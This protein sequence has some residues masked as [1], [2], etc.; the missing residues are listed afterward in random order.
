MVMG[1][2]LLVIEAG[3]CTERFIIFFRVSSRKST[4][5]FIQNRIDVLEKKYFCP[6]ISSL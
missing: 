1:Y 4:K 3:D 5:L 2:W 6:V